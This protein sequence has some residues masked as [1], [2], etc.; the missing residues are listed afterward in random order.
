MKPLKTLNALAVTLKYVQ[1]AVI[2]GPSYLQDLF[3]VYQQITCILWSKRSHMGIRLPSVV[4]K[5]N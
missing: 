5:K 1:D 3:D 4:H 2:A